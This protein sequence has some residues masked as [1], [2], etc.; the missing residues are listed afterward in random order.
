MDKDSSKVMK[1]KMKNSNFNN[2]NDREQKINKN[3]FSPSLWF[4]MFNEKKKLIEYLN[5]KKFMGH[6]YLSGKC[7]QYIWQQ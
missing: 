1:N 6:E 2:N 4:E 7:N 3:L 5:G